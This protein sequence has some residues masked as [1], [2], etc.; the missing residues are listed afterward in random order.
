MNIQSIPLSFKSSV[1]NCSKYN[2]TKNKEKQISITDN[3]KDILR[4]E[5]I[6]SLYN[7]Y[8]I[9]TQR[10]TQS[11]NTPILPQFESEN[12]PQEGQFIGDNGR[13]FNRHTTHYVRADLNWKDLGTFLEDRFKNT[14]KVNTYIY[15]CSYGEEAYSLLALLS[16]KTKKPQKY[17]PIKAKDITPELIERNI[18][19]QSIGVTLS[20]EE[21]SKIAKGIGCN[22][23]QIIEI[24]DTTK[25]NKIK[26]KNRCAKQVEFEC[27]NIL[28]DIESIDSQNPAIVMAR[29]MWPYISFDKY[30]A[31]AQTLYDKLAPGSV[32]IIG[33]FD[34]EGERDLPETKAFPSY[35]KKA[36]FKPT[37]QVMPLLPSIDEK[38]IVY[39][40]D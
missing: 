7:D 40:K 36:G 12:S 35:L 10:R 16:L 8:N 24:L 29:N 6:M 2:I 32:V 33:S 4:K 9:I 18:Q 38:P 34:N 19:K 31:F 22:E 13:V 20:V 26:I 27:A 5:A 23:E 25:D 30:E 11:T 14:P 39:V 37:K 28:L 3:N 15:G 21:I 17:F 1:L